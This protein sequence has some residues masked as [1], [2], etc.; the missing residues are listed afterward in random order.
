MTKPQEFNDQQVIRHDSPY[1]VDA[2]FAKGPQAG[3]G[4]LSVGRV[5]WTEA[6][7]RFAEDDA[8]VSA[9]AEGIGVVSVEAESL[10][11]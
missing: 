2:R 5:V 11:S 9:F 4:V 3:T 6:D 8:P 7:A 10:R 1:Q